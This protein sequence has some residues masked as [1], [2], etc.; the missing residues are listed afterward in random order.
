M[1]GY[2]GYSYKGRLTKFFNLFEKLPVV[3]V[4]TFGPD[5]AEKIIRGQKSIKIIKVKFM[6][7]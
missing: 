7:G 2:F 1:Y 3:R 6:V 5:L 4:G